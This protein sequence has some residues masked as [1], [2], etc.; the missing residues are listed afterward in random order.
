MNDIA[1]KEKAIADVVE[2]IRGLGRQAHGH[3]AD[4]TNQAEVQGLISSCVEN[5]GP[6]NVLV[7]NAGLTQIQPLL[8]VPEEDVRRLIDVNILG[9][10]NCFQLAAKQFISQK[11]PGKLIAASSIAGHKAIPMFTHYS[12]TKFAVR[13]LVQG[14]ALELASHGITANGY[15]PGIVDTAMLDYIDEYMTKDG[16]KPGDGKKHFMSS[17]PLGRNAEPADQAKVV[18]FLAGPDSDYMTGQNLLV[19][20]GIIMT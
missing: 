20:G 15:C 3:G 16:G 2:T 6:L 8:T 13:G 11:T 1:S 4:V 14:F 19:D 5:L 9:V 12:A 18:S 10:W 17:V 7:A